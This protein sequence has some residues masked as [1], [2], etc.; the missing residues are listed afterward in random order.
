MGSVVVTWEGW[1]RDRR[2][3]ERLVA[4]LEPFAAV[5]NAFLPMPE[6]PLRLD[7]PVEGIALALLSPVQQSRLTESFGSREALSAA[8]REVGGAVVSS[9]WPPPATDDPAGALG[10]AAGVPLRRRGRGEKWFLRLPNAELHGIQ[11]RICDPRSPFE[12][13]LAVGFVHLVVPGVPLLDGLL[14]EVQE[15]AHP[16]AFD[17]PSLGRA[18]WRLARPNICLRHYL[19]TWFGRFLSWVRFFHVPDLRTEGRREDAGWHSFE[20]AVRYR[21]RYE[22]G[23]GNGL[24]ARIAGELLA[25]FRREAHLWGLGRLKERMVADGAGGRSCL[26]ASVFP[27][28]ARERPSV[29]R[30]LADGLRMQGRLFA[31]RPGR[32]SGVGTVSAVT[33]DPSTRF[34]AESSS[35][36]RGIALAEKRLN[37]ARWLLEKGDGMDKARFGEALSEG[38]AALS[39]VPPRRRTPGLEAHFRLQFAR[40]ALGERRWAAAIEEA[41]RAVSLWEAVDATRLVAVDWKGIAAAH[42][43]AADAR[44]ALGRLD[45]AVEGL[46]AGLERLQ[47]RRSD[48]MK[49]PLEEAA[50]LAALGMR[51]RA[52]GRPEDARASFLGA[53]AVHAALVQQQDAWPWLWRDSRMDVLQ[54]LAGL[55][56]AS[57]EPDAALA[58]LATLLSL[59]AEAGARPVAA[60]RFIAEIEFRRGRY[61][62]AAEAARDGLEAAYPRSTPPSPD[63]SALEELLREI[64]RHDPRTLADAPVSDAPS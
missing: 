26:S 21:S 10:G 18:D 37:D 62:E 61:A 54:H 4:A 40:K 52:L 22:S 57:G 27:A 42:S 50:A 8:L 5:S 6:P 14:F 56:A 55:E 23:S 16:E 44:E 3:R 12:P 60:L 49:A 28:D 34:D 35:D 38:F 32:E 25:E 64:R 20:R 39:K 43:I 63:A 45:Q 9:D 48:A 1:N 13:G 19:E 29:L 51:Q 36:K 47:E 24:E 59:S 7:G 30:A 31:A 41:E 53:E 11:W 2:S 33:G 58:H 17:D 46:R 15:A